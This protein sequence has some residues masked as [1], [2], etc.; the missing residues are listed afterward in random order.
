[1]VAHHVEDSR[2]I[3]AMQA[4]AAQGDDLVLVEGLVDPGLVVREVL[5]V[6]RLDPEGVAGEAQPG[7]PLR[8]RLLLAVD[9]ALEHLVRIGL[10]AAQVPLT[11][12]DDVDAPFLEVRL[13]AR[14]RIAQRRLGVLHAEGLGGDPQALVV[15][16][17]ARLEERHQRVRQ[18]LC[19]RVEVAEVAPPRDVSNGGNPAGNE[20]QHD[21]LSLKR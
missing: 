18:I 2:R 6:L 10:A 8:Q 14:H 12:V 7:V 19:C 3:A 16:L 15:V 17:E 4:V 1:V 20:R 13:Q 5:P 11:V 9:P 21:D